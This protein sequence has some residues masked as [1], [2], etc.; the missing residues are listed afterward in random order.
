[1]DTSRL[2]DSHRWPQ[3][4]PDQEHFLFWARNAMG[5]GEQTIRVGKLGTTE[6]KI[7]LKTANAARYAAGYMLFMREHALLAQP[8]DPKRLDLTGEPTPVGEHLAI[9]SAT[10]VPEFSASETGTLIYETGEGGGAWDLLWFTRDGKPDGSIAQQERYYYPAL[11]PDGNLLAVS[12]FNGTEGITN[13]WILDLK[14]GTKSRFTFNNGV[15][16]GPVWSVDGKTLYYASSL[17]GARHI[18]A[19]AADGSGTEQM[20]LETQGVSEFPHSF[21]ADGRYLLYTHTS[22][23]SPQAKPDIWALPMFGDRRPFSIVETPFSSINPE[24]SPVGKWMAYQN[25]ESGRNEIY[26]TQ[27]PGGGAK[28]Q[29]SSNGGVDPKWRGDGKELYFLDLSD[30]VMAVDVDTSGGTPKLGVP[31]V[32]FQAIG[33]QRQVG[34]YVVMRDG[35]KFLI[36]SG[37]TKAGAEPLT[38]V[39]NWT[40]DLKK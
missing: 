18:Y 21:T 14:R 37:S 24:A 11:S 2:E 8:F 31:H 40:A 7:V 3:F 16:I 9:N 10:N 28:W 33:V 6:A 12:L 30:N 19:K 5:T 36:N 1:V 17:K 39:T 27:V 26:V 22:E 38:L 23:N 13:L 25:N 20:I 35:R 29:V 32:L 34:T 15:Q 4:L